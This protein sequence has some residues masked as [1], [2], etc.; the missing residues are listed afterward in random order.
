M[1]NLKMESDL[2][3][4]KSQSRSLC[5]KYGINEKCLNYVL[6]F[7]FFVLLLSLVIYA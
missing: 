6:F 2:L 4:L 5:D 7:I 1:Y 3:Q